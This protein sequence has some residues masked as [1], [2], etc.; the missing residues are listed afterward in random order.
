[1]YPE[2]TQGFIKGIPKICMFMI[3]KLDTYL[4]KPKTLI[5]PQ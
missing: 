5:I 2:I 1:M 4:T 3:S